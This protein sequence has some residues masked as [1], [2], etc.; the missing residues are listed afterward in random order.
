[1][2]VIKGEEHHSPNLHELREP[3]RGFEKEGLEL[4]ETIQ[5]PTEYKNPELSLDEAKEHKHQEE[6]FNDSSLK[7]TSASTELSNQLPAHC[8]NQN[9]IDAFNQ[10]MSSQL[11]ANKEAC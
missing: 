7:D 3:V 6:F 4:I 11:E 1:M 2:D 10:K 5:T 8:N 9:N